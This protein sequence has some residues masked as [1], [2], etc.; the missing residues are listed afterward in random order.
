MERGCMASEMKTRERGN[1]N[2]ERNLKMGRDRKRNGRFKI[3]NVKKY[4]QQTVRKFI[5][6]L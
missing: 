2:V 3:G 5:R 1:G 4:A 6:A